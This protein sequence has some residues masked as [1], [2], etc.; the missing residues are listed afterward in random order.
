MIQPSLEEVKRAA[1]SGAYK[2]FPV[3]TEI[4]ADIRTPVETV[5]ILKN[6]SS[7]VFML[8][9]VAGHEK[10]GRYT[11]LGYQPKTILS[12]Q[13]GRI[14]LG[15]V[16]LQ[17]EHP[18]Q[19]IRQ[20]LAAHKSPKVEGLPPFTG[21]LVGYFSYDYLKYAEPSLHL[22]AEDT[23]NFQDVDLMLF[24]KVI[25]YDSLLQ[26]IFLI[27][28]ISLDNPEEE[29]NRAQIELREMAQLIRERKLSYREAAAKLNVSP[30]W[31]YSTMKTKLSESQQKKTGPRSGSGLFLLWMNQRALRI[32][33]S[34]SFMSYRPGFSTCARKRAAVT[35]PLA[36]TSRE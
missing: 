15:D 10:F 1:Q 23:E 32:S 16:T 26:K 3:Y 29:Y 7:H 34:A 6:I 33:A 2:A 28:N 8:E 35:A 9:S 36:K 19:Y 21:G 22:D 12:C 25:A 31:L 5:R 27:C 11:L 18:G 24:D 4:L 14:R 17:T 20:L 13:N 30:S